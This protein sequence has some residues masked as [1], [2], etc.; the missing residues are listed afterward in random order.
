[1]RVL[2]VDPYYPQ[3]LAAHYDSRP[4]L[5]D[6]SY[7]EQWRALM[8]LAF[9]TSDAYSFNLR[10]LGHD[11]H[12]VVPN[13]RPLQVAWAREHAPRLARLP[14]RVAAQAILLAQARR[15][16]ADVVY[17]Q[18]IGAFRPTI[19]KALRRGARLLAGQIA[20]ALPEPD[21][22]RVY[23]L[24]LTSFPH[25]VGRLE[26]PTELLRIGFDERVLDRVEHPPRYDVVFIGQLGGARHRGGNRIV[27]AAAQ[28]IAI[29]VWGPGIEEWPPD[30][31]LRRRYH[32]TAWGIEMFAILKG[33]R[34][35]INRH[36]DASE[37]YA[38]NMRLFEATG[39]G[40]LLLTDDLRGLADLFLPGREAI[41][42][43]GPDELVEKVRRY[44]AREEERSAVAAAGQA[45]TLREHT[46]RARMRELVAILERH[47]SR[48]PV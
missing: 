44:L 5:E 39:M 41:T 27:E 40:T 9:G 45:R 33:A 17:V 36:I 11:A 16:R 48:S 20:S 25:F 26:V 15:F 7:D 38:N 21:R 24:L 29:D 31:P 12:E 6:A 30:S 14:W 47:L 46:Y 28:Q 34:I 43:D 19:L 8:D 1:M 10:T 37:G 22:V 42:Y 4:W 32:G 13:A 23:D 2:I 3:V 18:S 35:A